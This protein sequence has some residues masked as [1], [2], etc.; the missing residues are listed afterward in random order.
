MKEP[1]VIIS[2][3]EYNQLIKLRDANPQ[4]KAVEL[5]QAILKRILELQSRMPASYNAME[6]LYRLSNNP[7][8]LMKML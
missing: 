8:E 3:E 6:V 4:K 7:E 5:T 2:L 1:E